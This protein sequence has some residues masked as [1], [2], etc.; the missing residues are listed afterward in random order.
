[1][2]SVLVEFHLFLG[3]RLGDPR[4]VRPTSR[5]TTLHIE[6]VALVQELDQEGVLIVVLSLWGLLQFSHLAF[7]VLYCALQLDFLHN[8]R[9]ILQIKIAILLITHTARLQRLSISSASSKATL[10]R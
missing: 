6:C 7:L 5:Q 9:E 8:F 2:L 1:M 10:A 3:R 4:P